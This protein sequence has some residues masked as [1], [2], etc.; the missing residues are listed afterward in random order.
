MR[1]FL[2]VVSAALGLAHAATNMLSPYG[3]MSKRQGGAFDPDEQTGRGDTCIE[4]FGPGYIECRPESATENS[5]CINPDEGQSCCQNLWGCPADSF[6]LVDGLCCPT[7]LDPETCASENGVDLPPNFG[8]STAPPIEETATSTRTTR[9]STAAPDTTSTPDSETTSEP[10]TTTSAPTTSR[11]GGNGTTTRTTSPS[12]SSG[13]VTAA[14]YQEKAG[15]AAVV[16]G[17]A[18]AIAL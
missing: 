8:I 13:V 12:S 3:A 17:L 18:A 6:C 11:T 7:G 16:M 10:A 4:A 9:V 1:T 2:V 15:V 14:A 5:L